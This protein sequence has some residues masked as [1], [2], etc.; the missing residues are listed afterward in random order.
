MAEPARPQPLR[1]HF[2]VAYSLT[3]LWV[4]PFVS[5]PLPSSRRRRSFRSAGRTTALAPR[6]CDSIASSPPNEPNEGRDDRWSERTLAAMRIAHARSLALSVCAQCASP[7]D[8]PRVKWPTE[9]EGGTSERASAAAAEKEEINYLPPSLA[10]RRSFPLNLI[11]RSQ[12]ACVKS[13][14]RCAVGCSRPITSYARKR[15]AVVSKRC[16]ESTK[17]QP[18]PSSAVVDR[19][20]QRCR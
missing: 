14:V 12:N 6:H 19:Q 16:L 4:R 3:L 7:N 11:S 8:R 2:A 20:R 1:F 13:D 9:R 5:D 15:A 10:P 18:P 17:S